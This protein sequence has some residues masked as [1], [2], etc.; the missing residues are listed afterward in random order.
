M[1]KIYMVS[2][3]GGSYDDF[4]TANIFVT[5][6]KA[7]ATKYVTRFNKLLKKWKKHYSQYES[8]DFGMRWISPE[9]SVKH[10]NRWHSLYN[11]DRCYYEELEV[12]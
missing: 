5:T 9:H 10:F 2:Y 11:V 8:N 7:T 3:S 6:N 12:R 1:S 4:Y